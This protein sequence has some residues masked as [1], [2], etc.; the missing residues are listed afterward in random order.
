MEGAES[1]EGGHGE[2]DGKARGG[3]TRCAVGSRKVNLALE[4]F[5]GNPEL[6]VFNSQIIKNITS[7]FWNVVTPNECRS[8]EL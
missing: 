2:W 4:V 1:I 7:F 6:E 3:G 8:C 5:I